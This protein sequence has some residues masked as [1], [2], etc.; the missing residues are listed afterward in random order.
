MYEDEPRS[1]TRQVHCIMLQYFRSLGL[2]LLLSVCVGTVISADNHSSTSAN[3]NRLV[4]VDLFGDDLTSMGIKGISLAECEAI[5]SED[6][7][8]KAYSFIED[9]RWCFPKSG[10]GNKKDNA[11]VI[12]GVKELTEILNEQTASTQVDLQVELMQGIPKQNRDAV[13][14]IIKDYSKECSGYQ[15]VGEN[16][17]LKI[18]E[19]NLKQIKLLQGGTELTVLT[20][21]FECPGAGYIWSGTAGSPTYLIIDDVIYQMAGGSP[22]PFNISEDRTVLINWH[23]GNNCKTT[24]GQSYPNSGA[25][26]SS[27]YWSEDDKTFVV[28][29]GAIK[30]QKRRF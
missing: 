6:S 17:K 7:S 12:S 19:D 21:S 30:L 26:F 11:A 28:F 13:Q 18:E 3:F 9:K 29:D 1:K 27:M 4:G 8:C 14:R 10:P 16:R 5:C 2:A 25:C 20:A 24:N 15:D 22:Y 23:G